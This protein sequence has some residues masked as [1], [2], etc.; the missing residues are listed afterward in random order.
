MFPGFAR[1]LEL[2]D[3]RDLFALLFPEGREEGLVVGLCCEGTCL[4]GDL[5][6]PPLIVDGREEGVALLFLLL[7]GLEAGRDAGRAPPPPLFA[8]GL[9]IEPPLP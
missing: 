3:G 4:L 7:D 2:F 8:E 1:S 5:C 6:A 9:D